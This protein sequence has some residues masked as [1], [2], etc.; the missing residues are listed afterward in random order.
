M[1]VDSP[2]HVQRLESKLFRKGWLMVIAIALSVGTLI[3]TLVLRSTITNKRSTDFCSELNVLNAA[4]QNV[5]VNQIPTAKNLSKILYYQRNP[6]E[7]QKRIERETAKAIPELQLLIRA[8][9]GAPDSTPALNALIKSI[10][11]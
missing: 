1:N 6:G 5:V 8:E 9:C 10:L 3:G 2:R 7:I 11:R 4:V